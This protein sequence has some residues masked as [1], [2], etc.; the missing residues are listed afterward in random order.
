[1]VTSD[2][3]LA[4]QY[5]YSPSG[6]PFGIP[7]GD[8]NGDGKCEGGSTGTDKTQINGLVSSFGSSASNYHV[9]GDLNL[10]GQVNASDTAIVT[11]NDGVTLGR[12]KLSAAAISNS[13]CTRAAE[14]TALGIYLTK[15][16]S[17]APEIGVSLST[18]RRYPK[19]SRNGNISNSS[20]KVVARFKVRSSIVS[21]I[22][23]NEKPGTPTFPPGPPTTDPAGIP[24]PAPF[25]PSTPD[26]YFD[27]FEPS[28]GGY[29]TPDWFIVPTYYHPWKPEYTPRW[30]PFDPDG[31]LPDDWNEWYN[32]PDRVWYS[33]FPTERL[34]N[35]S[36]T[37]V[38]CWS[39][40]A[41]V[42]CGVS[43]YGVWY[44]AGWCALPEAGFGSIGCQATEQG[45]YWWM[46]RPPGQPW[47]AWN[48]TPPGRWI[49]PPSFYQPQPLFPWIPMRYPFA[50]VGPMG[51]GTGNC[52]IQGIWYIIRCL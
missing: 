38:V 11:A 35:M 8:V 27:P 41:S 7:L 39:F 37:E 46:V 51:P 22:G 33:L 28:D 6:V 9:R 49:A 15:A 45:G 29:L 43:I 30:F 31:A 13:L 23:P 44:A 25:Q 19:A 32:I 50:P 36:D 12:G 5:R 40:G 3:K 16:V 34:A 48:T 42:V 17:F 1:M 2:G 10:D 20:A 21:P 14:S 24:I 47:W 4:E 18:I 52:L 26:N